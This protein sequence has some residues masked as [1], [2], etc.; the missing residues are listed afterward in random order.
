MPV[1]AV[2]SVAAVLLAAFPLYFVCAK[3]T[4]CVSYALT[5]ICAVRCFIGIGLSVSLRLSAVAIGLAVVGILYLAFMFFIRRRVHIVSPLIATSM[6]YLSSSDAV[7]FAP[8]FLL[9]AGVAACL[10][11]VVGVLF[12]YGIGQP[13]IDR[14]HRKLSV[15]KHGSLN[16]TVI[17]FPFVGIWMLEFIAAWV[18]SSV[19]YIV[20]SSYFRRRIP[21]FGEALAKVQAFH[22]GTLFF[23]SF[24]VLLLENVSVFLRILGNTIKS[25]QGVFVKFLFKCVI[26]ICFCMVQ[27]VGEVNRLSFVFTAMKG[28]SFWDG[29]VEAMES[30]KIDTVLSIDLLMHS[31]FLSVRVLIT[32]VTAIVT[33]LSADALGLAIPWIPVGAI[34]VLVYI[35]LAA[36]D[37]TVEASSETVLVCLCEDAKDGGLYG[38][39]CLQGVTAWLREKLSVRSYKA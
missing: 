38:P 6:S 25:K 30:L 7:V 3:L 36:V 22:T 12:A 17:L 31:V 2:C 34:L 1:P 19:A 10:F 37:V 11:V 14:T 27:F 20:A 8:L 35:A 24:A 26:S 5:A 16:A 23:G 18:R 29:C 15:V 21:S 32:V 4:V 28:L 13:A 9:L 33:Y 39:E